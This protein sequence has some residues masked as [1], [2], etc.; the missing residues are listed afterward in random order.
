MRQRRGGCDTQPPLQRAWL[1]S[2][3]NRFAKEHTIADRAADKQCPVTFM[4]GNGPWERQGTAIQ[5][6][7]AIGGI[8]SVRTVDDW[9]Y[10]PA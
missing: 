7:E 2:G 6:A 8:T 9:V 1:S 4:C 10:T 5:L 3:G